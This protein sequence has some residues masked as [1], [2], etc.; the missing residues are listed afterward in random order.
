MYQFNFH[1]LGCRGS[2]N[3]RHLPT[4]ITFGVPGGVAATPNVSF[5]YDHAGNRTSM[6]DGL[7]SVS[8]SYDTLSQMTSETRT[9][10]G[11]TGTFSLNYVYNLA[12]KLT[13]VTNQ[14]NAQVGYTYD[15]VVRPTSISRSGYYGVSSYVNSIGYRAFGM[16]QMAS[17]NGRTLSL[18]YDNRQRVT[19]WDVPGVMG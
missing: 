4:G 15:K 16:K 19:G 14:W 10:T 9:F 6:T 3:S 2:Y 12:G 17:A 18:T 11:L 7:G 1:C 8:Y 13:S 5:S